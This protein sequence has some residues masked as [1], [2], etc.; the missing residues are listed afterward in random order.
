MSK[1]RIAVFTSARSDYGLLR[2]FIKELQHEAEVFLLA[3]GAHFSTSKG[4]TFQE[5]HNDG[6]VA[7]DHIIK[8]CSFLDA[9]S[10]QALGKSI[11][12]AQISFA[13]IFEDHPMDALVMLGDRFELF[14]A[15]IPAMLHS[16]PIFHI[17]GGE[18]TDGVVDDSIRHAHTKLSH[19]HFVAAREYAEN[20]SRMGEEDW[21]ICISG[22]CGLD[23]IYHVPLQ[24][25]EQIR[26]L[27]GID[28]S[29][30]TLL[31]TF[32]PSSLDFSGPVEDQ[33]NPLLAAL[34]H[35]PDVQKVFTAPG[36]EKGSDSFVNRI[37]QFLLSDRNGL[38]EKNLGRTSYLTILKKCQAVVGNS[39]SGIVEAPSLG[40]STINIGNRQNNR[41]HARSVTTI[42]NAPH[43]IRSAL[44][45]VLKRA[46][47][48]S[49]KEGNKDIQNPYDPYHDGKNSKRIVYGILKALADVPKTRLLQKKFLP[50]VQSSEW[51]TLLKGF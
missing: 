49:Q 22:E 30:K 33:I 4:N 5:I 26:E 9:D 19:L 11:G 31:I 29:K 43:Q 14:G 20:V 51:D 18:I 10:G 32:H 50:D 41:V 7:D 39:S 27:F 42:P 28:L 3:T 36:Y 17:S 21:R 46:T 2:I 35:F 8:I 47:K 45:E 12:L 44:D 1:K 25:D 13:Q 34:G 23:E 24:T 40:V 16:I 6:I 48:K 37:H 38:F 15:S